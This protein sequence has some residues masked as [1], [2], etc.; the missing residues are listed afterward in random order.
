M[1]DIH[2]HLLWAMDDG[3][4]NREETLRMCHMVSD[5]RVDV[6]VATPHSYDDEFINHPSV[7]RSVVA[8]LNEYPT[9][10]GI[11]LKILPGM[12]VQVSAE[13]SS[14]LLNGEI[15]PLN[16]NRYV[17]VEFHPA[18]IPTGFKNLVHQLVISGYHSIL[19]HSEQNFGIQSPNTCSNS[20]R[21][22]T[23]SLSCASLRRP[24]SWT[25]MVPSL[26]RLLENYSRTTGRT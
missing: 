10:E 20:L 17:L 13:L 19:A 6:I 7:I 14:R 23:R 8:D 21:S 22:S 15:L 16:D 18:H 24:V 11:D 1:I 2:N 25:E 26:Q 3:A 4:A 5:D 12:E 9:T